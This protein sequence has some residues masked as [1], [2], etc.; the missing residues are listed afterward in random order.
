MGSP[1][2]FRKSVE[3]RRERDHLV[4]TWAES[5]LGIRGAL[6][7][8]RVRVVLGVLGGWRLSEKSR[9]KMWAANGFTRAIGRW[10]GMGGACGV[11]GSHVA[12]QIGLL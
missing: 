7:L 3:D 11:G 6:R 8:I 9:T 5:I 2:Y 10:G 1:L 12:I 4:K